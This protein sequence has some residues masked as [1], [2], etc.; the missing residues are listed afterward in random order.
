VPQACFAWE[1]HTETI[2]ERLGMD[3][4]QFRMK[5]SY[6]EGDISPSGQK[7]TAVGLKESMLQARKAFGLEKETSA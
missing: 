1:S 5:N 2:A 4:F 6:D 3:A 7:L